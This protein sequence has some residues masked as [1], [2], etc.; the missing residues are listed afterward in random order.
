MSTTAGQ[1]LDQVLDRLEESRT[2][3]IWVSRA[4]LLVH[5]NDAFLE[6]TLIAGQMTSERTY[7]LIGAKLQSVPQGAIAIIHVSYANK[8]IR[9]SSIE[10]FDRENPKWDGLA[11]LLTKWGPAGL[12][13]WA[14]DRHPTAA[15]TN[16]TLVTLDDPPQLTEAS[17]IDL[18]Q[19][20]IDG[21]TEY[22]FH[23]GRFKEGGA[24]FVQ[25]M[26]NYDLFLEKSGHQAQRTFSQQFTS[27]S[28]DPNADT[29]EGYSTIDRS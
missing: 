18:A 27:F 28:R 13:R 23:F 21:L 20:Y 15:G 19:E 4:E 11:G 5:L 9:K 25:A 6:Y 2:N 7:A 14:I 3:P 24:E 8:R 29:G 1:I 17:V 22:T 12:D 10:N 26:P 16:V